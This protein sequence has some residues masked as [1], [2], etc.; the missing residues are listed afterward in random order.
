MPVSRVSRFF[1]PDGNTVMILWYVV[2]TMDVENY[3]GDV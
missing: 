2:Y 3:C 1:S